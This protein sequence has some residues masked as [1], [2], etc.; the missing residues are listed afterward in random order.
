MKP[1]KK[2]LITLILKKEY[3]FSKNEIFET[4]EFPK[5]RFDK[6][7]RKL[8]RKEYLEINKNNT[9]EYQRT[10]CGRKELSLLLSLDSNSK[11]SK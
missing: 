9:E 3:A 10:S 5:T 8:L 2:K 6:I 1:L 4:S 11:V 7:F